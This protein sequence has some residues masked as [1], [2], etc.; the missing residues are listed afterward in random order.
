MSHAPT[1]AAL[2]AWWSG[3]GGSRALRRHAR[4]DSTGKSVEHE[5]VG[6][7]AAL[8]GRYEIVHPLG[9]GGMATVYLARDLKHQRPVAVKVL[10]PEL[11]VTLAVQRF[12]REIRIT[13]GLLHPHILSL[14]DSGEI[15]GFLYYVMPYI[16]GVSL[17][18]RLSDE[19]YLPLCEAV[20]IAGAL[21][22]A[23]DHAHGRGVIH[24]DIKPENILFCGGHPILADFGVA[25]AVGCAVDEHLTKSGFS[26][27]TPAYMS[28]EQAAGI[29]ELDARSDVYSLA[30]VL[31][32]MLTGEPLFRGATPRAVLARQL[33]GQ[34]PA[35]KDARPE[36]P[37]SLDSVLERALAI[38]PDD[39]YESASA[40]GRALEPVAQSSC[41][42]EARRPLRPYRL[43][44]QWLRPLWL[45]TVLRGRR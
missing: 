32:E 16:E 40:L 42:C 5:S 28:P 7:A 38:N 27:G 34:L 35:V 29:R 9:R 3:P 43:R 24:R 14:I 36:I 8:G 17:R 18:E 31:Y 10:H 4:G 26:V 25:L 41:H 11:A 37:E 1:T 15:D 45:R 21:A 23:L 44:P 33:G 19:V 6:L 2:E 12:L 22:A 30:V 39:R 13:A 20:R